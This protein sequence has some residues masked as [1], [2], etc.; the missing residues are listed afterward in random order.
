ML[1]FMYLGVT[2]A[3]ISVKKLNNSVL[4]HLNANSYC[5]VIYKND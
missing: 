1:V 5:Q 4:N 3:G 2:S